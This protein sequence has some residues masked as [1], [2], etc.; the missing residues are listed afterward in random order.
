M[1]LRASLAFGYIPMS[2]RHIRVAFIPKPGKP[3]SQAKSLRPSSFTPFI[4]KTLEK[5]LG[6]HIRDGA[7]VE[8]PLDQNRFAYR[9]GMSTETALLQVVHRL[10]KFLVIKRSR[11][12]PSWM[13]RGH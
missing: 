9:A 8:K 4:L 7:L 1:L 2:W 3:L 6:R 11:W 12:A 5:L 10:E 13:L